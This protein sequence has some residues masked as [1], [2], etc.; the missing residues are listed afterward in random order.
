MV[1]K[2]CNGIHIIPGPHVLLGVHHDADPYLNFGFH[3]YYG[4]YVNLGFQG[5]RDYSYLLSGFLS[6]INSQI[7]LSLNNPFAL[8]LWVSYAQKLKF[9]LCLISQYE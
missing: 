9:Q 5:W 6:H 4:S 8:I 1:R 2:E 7:Y 3:L